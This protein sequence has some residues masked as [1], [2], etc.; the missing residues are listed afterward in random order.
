MV[1]LGGRKAGAFDGDPHRLLLEERYAEGPFQ[2]RLETGVRILDGNLPL[3]EVWVHRH[4]GGALL[5]T[6]ADAIGR[7]Q[8]GRQVEW[9]IEPGLSVRADPA[10][11]RIA[12]E[13][14]LRNA[15]KF[16]GRTAAPVIRVGALEGDAK[17]TY[18]VGDNGVGF[19]MAYAHGLFGAFKRLHRVGDFP[20]SG[21]GLAIVQRII[22][23]HGGEIRAEAKEDEGATFLFGVKESE[24]ESLE[25]DHPAG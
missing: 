15:W 8:P 16:T 2:D 18:F 5:Q 9:A 19:D 21:I 10:L 7:D 3:D 22:R 13:N 17:T 6:R 20:G 23:R 1:R 4:F 12:M 14:L 25:Q 11:M 24:N